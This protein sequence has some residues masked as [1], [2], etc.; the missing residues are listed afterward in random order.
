VNGP[1]A[2]GLGAI[3]FYRGPS[4]FEGPGHNYY[5]QGR[6]GIGY[7]FKKYNLIHAFVSYDY[8]RYHERSTSV[9]FDQQQKVDIGLQTIYFGIGYAREHVIIPN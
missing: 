1:Y 8:F 2:Y 9:I 3:G 6:L 4:D 7:Q 5:A